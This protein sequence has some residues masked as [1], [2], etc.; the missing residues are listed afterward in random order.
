MSEQMRRRF[1][2]AQEELA[3][4][5]WWQ[6]HMIERAE[7]LGGRRVPEGLRRT[8]AAFIDRCNA[9]IDSLSGRI[10]ALESEIEDLMRSV[11]NESDS[12]GL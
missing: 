12:T 9:E 5:L 10:W 11:G 4:A 3:R 8:K 7:E 6:R 1:D 2:E